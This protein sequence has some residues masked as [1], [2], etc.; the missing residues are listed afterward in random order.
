MIQ[1]EASNLFVNEILLL[2]N[3][4]LKIVEHIKLVLILR[5][6][7]YEVN[8]RL[9]MQRTLIYPENTFWSGKRSGFWDYIILMTLVCKIIL[10][11][12]SSLRP[13]LWQQQVIT[14][15]RMSRMRWWS[16]SFPG[17]REKYHN[18]L[19]FYPHYSYAQLV[20]IHPSV[21]IQNKVFLC[22]LQS[23]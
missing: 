9:T 16:R 22:E 3:Q 7:I 23:L 12:V 5:R 17:E 11:L 4:L 19:N 21:S 18:T 13:L 15:H 20:R 2:L 1:T 10:F 14:N 8:S 6:I